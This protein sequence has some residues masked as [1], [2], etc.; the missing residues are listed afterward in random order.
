MDI[1][2]REVRR[3]AFHHADFSVF[4][5]ARNYSVYA[6]VGKTRKRLC[7]LVY[8]VVFHLLF[9]LNHP[10]NLLYLAVLIIY[11]FFA[12]MAAK[13]FRKAY[14]TAFL[15][16]PPFV[17]LLFLRRLICLSPDNF[18]YPIGITFQVFAA[19]SY[20]IESSRNSSEKKDNPSD[21]VFYLA[22]FPVTFAGP[23]IRYPKF[24]S[25]LK[26]ENIVFDMKNC[27]LGARIFMTGFIKCAAVGFTLTDAFLK[28]SAL[29]SDSPSLIVAIIMLAILFFSVY[30]SFSGYSDMGVGIARIFGVRLNLDS[31]PPFASP[32]PAA[33]FTGFSRSL[34]GFIDEYFI[35]P[36]RRAVGGRH[37]YFAE[38]VIFTLTVYLRKC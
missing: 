20:I 16:A 34:R 36:L 7:I 31:H 35:F 1:K 22:F 13:K 29:D 33:Y 8:S 26:E 18:I 25:L 21:L 14:L 9:N 28:L 30:F 17:C 12:G 4:I 24:L 23:I 11:S 10:L 3:N 27:A 38:S 5:P 32:T 19:V 6:V 2:I 15:A 37:L